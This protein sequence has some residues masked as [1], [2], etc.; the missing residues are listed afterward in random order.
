MQR[1]C[2]I[3]P[4]AWSGGV[5]QVEVA[6]VSSAHEPIRP[7]T[8]RGYTITGRLA[9]KNCLTLPRWTESQAVVSK[10]LLEE[11][12]DAWEQFTRADNYLSIY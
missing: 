2:W 1:K 12:A 7:C 6:L 8:T 9:K 11:E 10:A 5:N 3:G 4:S